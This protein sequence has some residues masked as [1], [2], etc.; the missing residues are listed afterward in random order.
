MCKLKK[1]QD[2][3]DLTVSY[4]TEGK[5]PLGIVRRPQFNTSCMDSHIRVNNDLFNDLL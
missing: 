1:K 4:P 3:E 2:G 5:Q